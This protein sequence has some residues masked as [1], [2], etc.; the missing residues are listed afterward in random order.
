MKKIYKVY[1]ADGMYV[2]DTT[3]RTEALAYIAAC[4][5]CSK[6]G[7]FSNTSR[8]SLPKLNDAPPKPEG[9]EQVQ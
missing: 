2:G 4:G 9:E 8:S 5:G 3:D 6:V 7:G 1:N